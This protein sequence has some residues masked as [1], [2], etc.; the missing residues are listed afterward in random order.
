MTQERRPQQ[1]K[2]RGVRNNGTYHKDVDPLKDSNKEDK[3][4]GGSQ[5]V[6]R[7][8]EKVHKAHNS[9]ETNRKQMKQTQQQIWAIR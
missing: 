6:G 4:T 9:V 3:A 8:K 2:G 5:V 7:E 1:R